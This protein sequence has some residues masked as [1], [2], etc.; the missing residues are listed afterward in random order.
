MTLHP[1]RLNFCR[2]PETKKELPRYEKSIAWRQTAL[3][4]PVPD[5][6]IVVLKTGIEMLLHF[7]YDR[8]H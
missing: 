2:T 4:I 1:I 5:I 3:L 7:Y 6:G 8:K